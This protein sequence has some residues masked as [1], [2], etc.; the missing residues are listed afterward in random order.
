M[1]GWM[2]AVAGFFF[3]A[4]HPRLNHYQET[5]IHGVTLKSLPYCLCRE[6]AC[7]LVFKGIRC[8]SVPS[9]FLKLHFTITGS[10]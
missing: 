2:G 1:C 9:M 8:L 4:S 7:I 10:P 6:M 5:Y 3:S